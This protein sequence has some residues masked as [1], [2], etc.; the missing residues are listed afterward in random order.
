M[1]WKRELLLKA[2]KYLRNKSKQRKREMIK[3]TKRSQTGERS[4]YFS[5]SIPSWSR[6]YLLL[7]C[8]IEWKKSWGWSAF[9]SCTRW[10]TGCFQVS[11]PLICFCFLIFAG[12]ESFFLLCHLL[13]LC[14]LHSWQECCRWIRVWRFLFCLVFRAMSRHALKIEKH[15]SF[16]WLDCN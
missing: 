1:T 15:P 2:R 16:H 7:F 4:W 6:Y 10:S 11:S 5:C 14:L 12:D 13:I 3:S 8:R 9:V